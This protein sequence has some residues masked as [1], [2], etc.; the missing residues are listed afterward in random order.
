MYHQI[1]YIKRLFEN[2][3]FSFSFQISTNFSKE[4]LALAGL[5]EGKASTGIE[6]KSL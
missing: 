2:Q 5:V 6:T 1:Y 3:D 4:N